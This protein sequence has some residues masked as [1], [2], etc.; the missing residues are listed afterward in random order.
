MKDSNFLYLNKDPDITVPNLGRTKEVTEIREILKKYL[1]ILNDFIPKNILE[2]YWNDPL[3]D[4]FVYTY[5]FK[6]NEAAW[7][8]SN[9]ITDKSGDPHGILHFLEQKEANSY[10]MILDGLCGVDGDHTFGEIKQFWKFLE[11]IK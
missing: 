11:E 1:L 7:E 5:L 9:E 4:S 2:L 10:T 8:I 6:L 3:E